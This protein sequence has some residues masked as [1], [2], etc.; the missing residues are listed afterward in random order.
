[1]ARKIIIIIVVGALILLGIFIPKRLVSPTNPAPPNP[2]PQTSPAPTPEAKKYFYPISNY[3]DRIKYRW[4]GKQVTTNDQVPYCGA[5]FSGLHT[6]DDLEATA[7][8]QN[9]PVPVYAISDAT[10][11]SVSNISG[12]GGLIVLTV[13][14][15][16]QNYT[17]YYGHISLASSA[18]KAGQT[19]KAGDF[20]ANLG[21]GCSAETSG[22]RKHLHFAIRKGARVD[23]RG[24]V[25]S[26]LELENWINPRDFLGQ[27]KAVSK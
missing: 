22:E 4:F 7:A 9:T 6:G 24:Y 21:K 17:I 10:I 26:Q 8:E 13:N 27:L 5:P 14:I 19:V 3:A 15:Q 11:T 16:G 23:V 20:L 12:Y 25:Q 2:A 1:M 18:V